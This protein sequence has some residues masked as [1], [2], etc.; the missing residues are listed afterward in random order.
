MVG[1]PMHMQRVKIVFAAAATAA[2]IGAPVASAQPTQ[3]GYSQVGGTIQAS[4]PPGPPPPHH[5]VPP[6]SPP[7]STV[8]TPS[9]P[10]SSSLPFTG[11]DVGLVVGAG[12]L[13]V[14]LGLGVRRI[15]RPQSSRA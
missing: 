1:R 8:T 2:L 4:I 11:L 13:L 9:E 14:A 3:S 5:N 7:T 10:S 15:S 12:A 6:P